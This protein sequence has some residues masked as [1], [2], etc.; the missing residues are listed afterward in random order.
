LWQLAKGVGNPGTVAQ[1]ASCCIRYRGVGEETY[2]G[3]WLGNP[4]GFFLVE[5]WRMDVL[6]NPG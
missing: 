5:K 1:Q 6:G 3:G 4:E 2:S